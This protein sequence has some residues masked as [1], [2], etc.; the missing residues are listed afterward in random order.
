[1][2]GH[3]RE[4][5][6]DY[7]LCVDPL[8]FLHEIARAFKKVHM[9]EVSES[10]ISKL[11]REEG[12]CKKQLERRAM[13]IRFSEITR[14]TCDVN[15]LQ[16]LYGQLL[17]LDEMSTDS[18]SMVRKRGW[19]LK[20]Q[21]P[22]FRG[23]FSRSDRISVLAFLGV[24]GLVECY[25][26]AG[27]FDRAKFMDCVRDLVKSG[28]I[29]KYPGKR[30]VWILDGASIHM[31]VDLIDYIR[32]VGVKVIFLPAYCPFYNPIEIFFGIV[33]GKVQTV[34]RK[35]GTEQLVLFSVLQLF[36]SHDFRS[37]FR[38]CGYSSTGQ[39]DL[40]VNFEALRTLRGDEEDI[41]ISGGVDFPILPADEIEEEFDGF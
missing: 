32:S 36:S 37:I 25:Q 5:I 35:K 2:F 19:F 22:F 8:A 12:I 9:F 11:L 21:K 6:I 14:Y 17:F 24:D 23:I 26:T 4:W 7:V 29:E 15:M 34:Y 16:P 28:K 27:T 13:E 39:F 40:N 18:R 31:S 10:T 33:K 1:L 3:H 20:N 30:S 38:K 41:D